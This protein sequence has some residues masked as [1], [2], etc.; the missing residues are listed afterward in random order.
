MIG[1]AQINTQDNWM[2]AKRIDYSQWFEKYTW[3]YYWATTMMLTIGYGDI[4]PTT[5][6]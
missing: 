3:A 2:V 4:V 5:Y 6:Q 1:M